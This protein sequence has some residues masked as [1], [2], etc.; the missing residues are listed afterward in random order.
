[1]FDNLKEDRKRNIA[2]HVSHWSWLLHPGSLQ[3]ADEVDLAN[4]CFQD[5]PHNYIVSVTLMIYRSYCHSH[6]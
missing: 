2:L 4:Q 5:V 3:N 1:M 6:T